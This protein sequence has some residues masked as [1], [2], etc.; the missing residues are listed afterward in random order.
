MASGLLTASAG[1]QQLLQA[2]PAGRRALGLQRPLA[3]GRRLALRV[4]SVA[5]PMGKITPQEEL[6]AEQAFTVGSHATCTTVA[7]TS[8]QGARPV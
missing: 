3:P 5:A 1:A 7:C 8:A 6:S 4:N 2:R